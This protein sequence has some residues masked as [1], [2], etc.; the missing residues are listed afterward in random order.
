[1]QSFSI[2]HFIGFPSPIFDL[3]CFSRTKHGPMHMTPYMSED[4]PYSCCRVALF[5]MSSG[6]AQCQ[7]VTTRLSSADLNPESDIFPCV[8]LC[9]AIQALA[10]CPTSMHSFF[11]HFIQNILQLFVGNLTR[12]HLCCLF[13]D[14]TPYVKG[15]HDETT[16]S[17]FSRGFLPGLRFVRGA[18]NPFVP[19]LRYFRLY[20]HHKLCDAMAIKCIEAITTLGLENIQTDV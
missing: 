12:L 14:K 8:P 7:A 5:I 1:M 9:L 11:G 13:K 17:Q 3:L 6:R 20:F 19:T 18:M 2:Y 16:G 4:S 15:A 10:G